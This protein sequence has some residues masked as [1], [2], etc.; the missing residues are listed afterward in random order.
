MK[1][2]I[3]HGWQGS[4]KSKSVKKWPKGGNESATWVRGDST[5][6]AVLKHSLVGWA[7]AWTQGTR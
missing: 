1:Q 3:Q 5:K 7:G 4:Q 6:D 2:I